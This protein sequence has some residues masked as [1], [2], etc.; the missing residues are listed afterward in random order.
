MKSRVRRPAREIAEQ[1][2]ALLVAELD[3]A[4]REV[5]VDEQRL[6]AGLRVDADDRVDRHLLRLAVRRRVVQRGE[7]LTELLERRR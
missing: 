4:A 3:D 5:L 7:P 2:V 6:A 1:V